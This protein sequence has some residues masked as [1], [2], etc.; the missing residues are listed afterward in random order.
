MSLF[1]S[2]NFGVNI[3][4][5]A[6]GSPGFHG[7][8]KISTGIVELSKQIW[9]HDLLTIKSKMHSISFSQLELTN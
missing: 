4:N 8:T 3:T 7:P 6:W 5:H 9:M 2:T 1:F